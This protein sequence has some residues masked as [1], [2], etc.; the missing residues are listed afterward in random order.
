MIDA[1][2]LD[3]PLSFVRVGCVH[4]TE[5]VELL[6]RLQRLATKRLVSHWSDP[7]VQHSMQEYLETV[8]FW[9]RMTH[10]DLSIRCNDF[11]V[12]RECYA[13]Q[14]RAEA[15][16]VHD[17]YSAK[18]Q[19][20]LI[21]KSAALPGIASMCSGPRLRPKPKCKTRALRFGLLLKPKCCEQS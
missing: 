16:Y 5:T 8:T 17:R 11:L 20:P 15:H 6:T 21:T 2:L 12:S 3:L 13:L 14:E 18:L 1:P 19:A 7:S 9:H 10:D 4:K